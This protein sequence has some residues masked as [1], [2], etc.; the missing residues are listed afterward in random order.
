MRVTS[1]PA[2]TRLAAMQLPLAP[3]PKTAIFRDMAVP[4][5]QHDVP[6]LNRQSRWILNHYGVGWLGLKARNCKCYLSKSEGR[7][8]PLSTKSCQGSFSQS[9]CFSCQ[10]CS[11][12]VDQ[13]MNTFAEWTI[14][15]PNNRVVVPCTH[16]HC[17]RRRRIYGLGQKT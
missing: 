17:H 6:Y 15:A 1:R 13:S 14:D 9:R 11:I 3:V 8:P 10:G 16:L 12:A 7:M 4:L 5:E 2:S